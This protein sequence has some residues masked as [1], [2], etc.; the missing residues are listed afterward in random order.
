MSNDALLEQLRAIAQDGLHYA[1]NAH[2]LERYRKL[3]RLVGGAPDVGLTPADA[4]WSSPKV[5]T[6]AIIFD[7][8]Q[9]VLLMRRSDDGLWGLPGGWAEV[10]E[11]A[12]Q[13]IERE[14]KE[15]TGLTVRAGAV[16]DVSSRLAGDYGQKYTTY[17]LHFHCV[18]EGG[19]LTPCD[20]SLELGYFDPRTITA[21]HKDHGLAVEKAL[22]RDW[23]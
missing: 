16:I 21:W 6:D 14:V 19:T 2:D 8:R 18:V 15:E 23:R 20:E 11:T 9:R 22:S 3:H 7:A 13:A 10:G 5:G 17:H 4:G 12:R 1:G